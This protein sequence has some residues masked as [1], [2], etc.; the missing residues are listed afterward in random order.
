[1]EEFLNK[2]RCDKICTGSAYN[3]NHICVTKIN[4]FLLYYKTFNQLI[5]MDI[6]EKLGEINSVCFRKNSTLSLEQIFVNQIEHCI[7]ADNS[8]MFIDIINVLDETDLIKYT[9]LPTLIKS[10][11]KNNNLNNNLIGIFVDVI[12]NYDKLK[13]NLSNSTQLYYRDPMSNYNKTINIMHNLVIIIDNIKFVNNIKNDTQNILYSWSIF[14]LNYII[15]YNKNTNNY[16]GHNKIDNNKYVELLKYKN[17]SL[18]NKNFNPDNDVMIYSFLYDTYDDT[19]KICKSPN[20]IINKDTLNDFVI[21]LTNSSLID[22]FEASDL[23]KI[24]NFLNEN[25][26]DPKLIQYD[27]I[28][29]DSYIYSRYR[30]ESKNRTDCYT[31][32]FN[33]LNENS[34]DISVDTF[35]KLM[36]KRILLKNPQKSGI[37]IND[38]LIKKHFYSINYNPYKVKFDSSIELLREQSNQSG[39]LTKIKTLCKEVKPDI[40]CLQNACRHKNNIHTVRYFIDVHK[41]KVDIDSLMNCMLNI[42]N[43]STRYIIDG[44][45][46]DKIELEKKK[47]IELEKLNLEKTDFNNIIDIMNNNQNPIE[48]DSCEKPKK[49]VKTV[50]KV[51]NKVEDEKAEDKVEEKP[52]KVIHRVVKKKTI[53]NKNK[54]DE[55]KVDEN[56]VDEKPKK[57][58]RR[59]VKKKVIDENKIDDIIDE[60]KVDENKVDEKPKKVIHRVVKKKVIDENEIDDIIDEIKVDENKS[61]EKPKKVIRRVVKKK[62]IDDE[63]K[64]ENKVDE[65]KSEEKPKKIIKRVIK[66]KVIADEKNDSDSESDLDNSSIT[67]DKSILK[68]L[69]E[70]KKIT[71]K[72]KKSK[73]S[74]NK[75]KVVNKHTINNNINLDEYVIPKEYDFRK[76]YN[77]T[78]LG[79]KVITP[80]DVEKMSHINLRKNLLTYLKDNKILKPDD[81]TLDNIKFNIKNIDKFI[82]TQL[83]QTN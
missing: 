10:L 38:P 82:S 56:K 51:E 79:K 70:I 2:L 49:K 40:I 72:S 65:N 63:N 28:T 8:K 78:E 64:D 30:T 54:V 39:N 74:D 46:K 20:V 62:A 4:N 36:T 16:Y 34:V 21:K 47:K 50:T 69:D 61:E 48:N 77:L 68:T 33:F 37:D 15:K 60:N 35:N 52:K 55:N 75:I 6:F 76:D 17:D 14:F 44:F 45:R 26:S 27:Q 7:K 71:E 25:G 24:L 80:T 18:N 83:L 1:M 13:N 73:Q 22:T 42:G 67:S 3:H 57:V 32:I 58:I 9:G 66:K 5:P 11:V 23:E 19:M 59:V 53:D 41:L 43:T 81:M 12:Y 31:V 29:F